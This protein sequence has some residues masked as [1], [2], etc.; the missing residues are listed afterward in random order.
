MGP[1]IMMARGEAI[2]SGRDSGPSHGRSWPGI[3]R[4]ETEKPQRPALGLAPA[5]GRALV[6]DL[7]PGPG[8]RAR[9]R[10][11]RRRVVVRLDLH[12]RVCPVLPVDVPPGPR[13]DHETPDDPPLH[14]R[15]VVRVRAHRA[16]GARLLRLSDHL[17]ERLR[18]RLAVHH[19]GSVEDL[20]AA[21]LGV[22]LGEHRELDVGRVAPS[23]LE[24]LE[25]VVDLV[26]GE[27]EAH[28][29]VRLLDGGTS[30]ADH[31]DLGEGLR[32]H[33]AE[34][35]VGL[36]QRGENRFR[37]AVVEDGQGGREIPG[38]ALQV[39]GRAALDAAH[40]ALEAALPGDVGGLGGPG[41]D[42]PE[43]GGDEDHPA[44]K[45]AGR[46]RHRTVVE[47]PVEGL[48]LLVREVPL[49]LDE[50]PVL[51]RD[52]REPRPGRPQ[53][54]V[55]LVE[56][57]LREGRAAGQLED[58]HDG[59]ILSSF[60]VA[61]RVDAWATCNPYYSGRWSP[62]EPPRATGDDDSCRR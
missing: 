57:E 46:R 21:V 22:R 39:E 29:A 7:A 28:G 15:R 33:V 16:G 49:R 13:L 4:L 48:T 19:P 14:D 27:G 32:G 34:E 60:R 37:H 18:L 56:A 25:Q 35:E 2:R 61:G 20:V 53:R 47:E 12:Q 40:E 26:R 45:A 54:R 9:E 10:R 50:V 1:S 6:A 55:Q 3:R 24:V 51:R 8:G 30:P 31:V 11:D 52:D 42:G 38:I 41:R 43:A 5:P 36:V 23:A 58:R 62:P 44:A 59:A 17:E